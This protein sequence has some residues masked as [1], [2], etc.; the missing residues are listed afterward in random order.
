MHIHQKDGG[1]QDVLKIPTGRLQDRLQVTHHLM[2]FI[3]EIGVVQ[4][5]GCGIDADLS[6]DVKQIAVSD[7]LI[8]GTNGRG[9]LIGADDDFCHGK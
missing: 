1:F 2:G 6:G 5:S 7:S 3:D 8:V 9:G 4:L